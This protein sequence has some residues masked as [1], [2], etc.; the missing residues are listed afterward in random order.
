MLQPTCA[1]LNLLAEKQEKVSAWL[2]FILSLT[3]QLGRLVSCCW[4]NR[5]SSQSCGL[6][7]QSSSGCG[8]LQG[9]VWAPFTFEFGCTV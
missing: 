7:S 6:I 4:S 1:S 2:L 5:L 3:T 9:R 8:M